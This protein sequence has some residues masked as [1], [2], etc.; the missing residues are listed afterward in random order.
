MFKRGSKMICLIVVLKEIVIN[1]TVSAVEQTSLSRSAFIETRKNKRL[2]GHVMKRSTSPSSMS[3]SQLCLRNTWCTSTN[4]KEGSK[5]SDKGTCE[6][7]EH[8]SSLVNG[9][10]KLVDEPGVTFAMLFKVGSK[11]SSPKKSECNCISKW[12]KNPVT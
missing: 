2:P 4:F 5:Q 7:N 1:I 10:N 3:C 8:D 6:L 12:Q 9:D 11:F